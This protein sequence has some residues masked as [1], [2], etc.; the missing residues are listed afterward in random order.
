MS[1]QGTP[2]VLTERILTVVGEGAW[3]PAE[4]TNAVLGVA[5]CD[6]S[7]ILDTLWDLV[8]TGDL[9]YG[10]RNGQPS[11]RAATAGSIRLSA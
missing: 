1:I 9:V 4:V 5:G 3:S 6:R 2:A 8:D 11:F 7:D 10:T